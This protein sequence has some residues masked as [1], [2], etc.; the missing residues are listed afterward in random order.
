MA[1]DPLFARLIES[2]PERID[3]GARRYLLPMLHPLYYRKRIRNIAFR[4]FPL[5]VVRPVPKPILPTTDGA[6]L[7]S[8]DELMRQICAK[9]E[10]TRLEVVSQSRNARLVM[11]RHEFCYR[12]ATETINS[13]PKIGKFLANRDHTTVMNSIG[14]WCRKND[15][16]RPRGLEERARALKS[17][18]GAEVGVRV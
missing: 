14:A 1:F 10:L 3:D 6:G 15:L 9:H 11:A 17:K 2:H 8:L 13:Y 12:A 4:P 5:P 18:V 16:P 7:I